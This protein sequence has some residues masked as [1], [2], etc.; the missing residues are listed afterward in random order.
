MYYLSDASGVSDTHW[1][2]QDS[3]RNELNFFWRIRPEF[4]WDEDFDTYVAKYKGYM[5]YS[6]GVSDWRG[7]VGSTGL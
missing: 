1:F 4:K 5:R 7:L 2:L 6:Y 3:K